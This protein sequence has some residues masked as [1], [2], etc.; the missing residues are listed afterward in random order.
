VASEICHRRRVAAVLSTINMILSNEDEILIKVCIWKGT[1]RRSWRANFLRKAGQSV[2]L[3]SCS[4][5]CGTWAQLTGGQAAADR[6]VRALKKMWVCGLS[7]WLR[8]KSLTVSTFFQCGYKLM[9]KLNKQKEQWHRKSYLQSAWRKTRYFRHRKYQNLWMNNKVRG[10][11]NALC[12]RC[13]LHLQ[14]IWIF[15]FPR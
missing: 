14:K 1:Q 5:S 4:K 8:T 13:L 9:V 3:I 7:S 11:K 2:V 10:D 12:L 6:A 15:S